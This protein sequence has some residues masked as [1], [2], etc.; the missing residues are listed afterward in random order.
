MIVDIRRVVLASL[1]HFAIVFV[2]TL[3]FAQPAAMFFAAMATPPGAL[4]LSGQVGFGVLP[5]LRR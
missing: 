2:A 1:A 5:V 3:V 4:G